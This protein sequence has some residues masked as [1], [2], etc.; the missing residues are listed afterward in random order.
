MKPSSL[1]PPTLEPSHYSLERVA[2]ALYSLQDVLQQLL[3]RP[4]L[5]ALGLGVRVVRG[6]AAAGAT[7]VS[8]IVVIVQVRA[9]AKSGIVL[10]LVFIQFVSLGCGFLSLRD[11]QIWETR[12][13]VCAPR[14]GYS[15][16]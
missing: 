1:A 13:I 3:A 15:H 6:A 14:D 11:V 12:K 2:G 10:M 8:R 5:G 9:A 7:V 16:S 4:L